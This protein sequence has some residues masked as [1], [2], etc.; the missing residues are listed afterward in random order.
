MEGVRPEDLEVQDFDMSLPNTQ[1][2]RPL[3]LPS[4]GATSADILDDLRQTAAIQEVFSASSIT[5]IGH[6]GMGLVVSAKDITL[7]REQAIKVLKEPPTPSAAARFKGEAQAIAA[8]NHKNLVKVYR[9][10]VSEAGRPYFVMDL[11]KDAST[12]ETAIERYFDSA[13][14]DV[15]KV[16]WR[17]R[18]KQLMRF[19]L[20]TLDAVAY[21][22]D[23]SIIHHDLKPA[24]I[25][26]STDKE[27]FVTDFGL[28]SGGSLND[29]C[30]SAQEGTQESEGKGTGFRGT[31]RYASPDQL[32]GGGPV[33][34][35]TDVY[36][37]GLILR[38]LVLN[39]APFERC[40]GTLAGEILRQI[41]DAA[42]PISLYG[43]PL[44]INP[45]LPP[46]L[47]AIIHKA[48]QRDPLERYKDAREFKEDLEAFLD[49]REVQAFS[50]SLST[51][52][53]WAYRFKVGA[54]ASFTWVRVNPRIAAGIAAAGAGL[55]GAGWVVID[56]QNRA[57]EER[58]AAVEKQNRREILAAD[59]ARD[60]DLAARLL[61]DAQLA[62]KNGN[63][64]AAVN[65]V[66]PELLQ[67]LKTHI[68][69]NDTLKTLLGTLEREHQAR[70][71]L[72]KMRNLET[73]GYAAA[74]SGKA[75][76]AL[77]E[78]DSELLLKARECLLPK[79]LTD[80]GIDEFEKMMSSAHFSQE[81][82]EKI[83]GA[84]AVDSLCVML[85]DLGGRLPWDTTLPIEVRQQLAAEC[86]MIARACAACGVEIDGDP[87]RRAVPNMVTNVQF[88]IE[89]TIDPE[90]EP[91]VF[92]NRYFSSDAST[93]LL[94]AFRAWQGRP[95][96][97]QQTEIQI[98]MVAARRA[99]EVNPE[100]LL[101]NIINA[102]LNLRASHNN[103]STLRYKH[104]HTALSS[105]ITAY[106]QSRMGGVGHSDLAFQVFSLVRD[107][108]HASQAV[109]VASRPELLATLTRAN[110]V[111]SGNRILA[112]TPEFEIAQAMLNLLQGVSSPQIRNTGESFRDDPSYRHD[113]TLIRVLGDI[114][115]G[116]PVNQQDAES[117]LAAD[118]KHQAPIHAA[119]VLTNLGR[120]D[121]A[122]SL[123]EELC[124]RNPAWS[125]DISRV[126]PTYLKPLQDAFNVRL[127]RLT[128]QSR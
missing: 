120:Y 104:L 95:A 70:S 8:L 51:P 122:I 13:V 21:L 52:Q 25:L 17:G 78:F 55:I 12:L 56:R 15:T 90:T 125:Q 34:V 72:V 14:D 6:G 111:L 69:E 41:K 98:P 121:D 96:D 82:R 29:P 24:N 62:E 88:M 114:H 37:L 63:I 116:Q 42:D 127:S 74:I 79:G 119:M 100:G 108:A 64:D 28:S 3:P 4:R 18:D 30:L 53:K 23:R 86:R 76:G 68:H 81:Y 44:S 5:F 46:E 113:A 83:A 35:R 32:P 61:K 10:G 36:Q 50:S 80:D 91:P 26:I 118:L 38:H 126:V 1:L 7:N 107:V 110:A 57:A 31:V 67:D 115:A 97:V 47:V 93:A 105:L 39:E 106:G 16:Q 128:Q 22:H 77:A 58:L 89:R 73:A 112:G 117:L 2:R 49:G 92:G 71:M 124:A 99:L 54:V 59:I 123:L 101:E 20:E 45:A 85:T 102:H 84:I 48:L 40:H 65:L 9:F 109:P 11:V 33:T 87:E 19:F 66:R 43:D 27:V 94:V 103:D 60:R 75:P